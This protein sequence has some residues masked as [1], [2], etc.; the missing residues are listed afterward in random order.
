MPISD[1]P[2]SIGRDLLKTAA[3]HSFSVITI[4]RTAAAEEPGEI[5]YVNS[6]FEDLTG[7]Q[8]RGDWPDAWRLAGT[9]D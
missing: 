9:E 2:D 3:D 7:Y 1:L 8:A 6:A 4:T 5:I